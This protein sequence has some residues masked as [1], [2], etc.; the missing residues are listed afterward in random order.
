MRKN[1]PRIIIENYYEP[2]ILYLLS[3]G[4]SYGY[5]IQQHIE[6]QLSCNANISNIYRCLTRLNTENFVTKTREPGESGPERVVYRITP[7]GE[8]LLKEW[9]R[10]LQKQKKILNTL[11]TSCIET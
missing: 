9:V 7:E 3:Q 6:M 10:D 2:C 8:Y 11:I 1:C 4:P 5:K